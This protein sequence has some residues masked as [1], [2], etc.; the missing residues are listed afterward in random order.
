M[1]P[2][3]AIHTATRNMGPAAGLETGEVREGLLADLLV[4]D[5][6]PT[7]DIT[8]LQQPHLRKAVIKDGQLAYV[9]PQVFP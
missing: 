3:E 4:V 5:A 8:V 7:V 2:V 1:S 6:D 9:N